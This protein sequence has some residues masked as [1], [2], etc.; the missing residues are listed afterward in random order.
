MLGVSPL[1]L[2]IYRFQSWHFVPKMH[3]KLL[4]SDHI[5]SKRGSKLGKNQIHHVKA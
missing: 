3:Q 5:K 1:L 2:E 4:R